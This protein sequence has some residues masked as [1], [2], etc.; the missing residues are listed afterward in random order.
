MKRITFIFI[1]LA[2]HLS[3]YA[4]DEMPE[5]FR[6]A[7]LVVRPGIS[8][9][10]GMTVEEY[11]LNRE[12][13]TFEQA[14]GTTTTIQFG[15]CTLKRNEYNLVIEMLNEGKALAQ[16][17]FYLMLLDDNS[18]LINNVRMEQFETGINMLSKTYQEV[19]ATLV[20]F[21]NFYNE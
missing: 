17:T 9:M 1:L 7:M 10:G 21:Q 11:F 12:F 16:F 2:I 18:C 19:T 14:D 20:Y 15:N 13:K 6:K 8:E 3:A 5:A 4:N